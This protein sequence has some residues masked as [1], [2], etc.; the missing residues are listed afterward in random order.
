[1][2]ERPARTRAAAAVL[3]AA[4][5]AGLLAS[6]PAAAFTPACTREAAAWWWNSTTLYDIIALHVKEAKKRPALAQLEKV[7]A[8]A[9]PAFGL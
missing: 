4:A 7:A 1:M 5:L 9:V 2:G 8:T 6:S 3:C